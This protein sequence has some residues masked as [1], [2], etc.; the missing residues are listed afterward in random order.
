V[1]RPKP[2]GD[3]AS[4]IASVR[5]GESSPAEASPLF[6]AIKNPDVVLA[7][8]LLGKLVDVQRRYDPWRSPRPSVVAPTDMLPPIF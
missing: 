7:S 8:T 4:A 2:G 1:F 5:A 6:V 3:L